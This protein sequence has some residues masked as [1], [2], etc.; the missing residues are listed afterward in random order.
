MNC[1]WGFDGSQI[2]T[3]IPKFDL[4]NFIG[5][6]EYICNNKQRNKIMLNDSIYVIKDLILYLS[7][8]M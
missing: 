3:Y 6:T 4:P 2:I 5:L 7:L 1:W 8:L